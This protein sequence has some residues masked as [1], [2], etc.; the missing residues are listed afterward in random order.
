MSRFP[1]LALILLAACSAPSAVRSQPVVEPTLQPEPTLSPITLP[2]PTEAQATWWQPAFGASWQ[3][4]FTG[5]VIDTSLPVEVFDLDL[6]DTPAETVDALHASGKRVM[7]Y[8]NVG[9]WEDWRPDVAD[10]PAEVLG[11]DY[12]GWPGE[13]WLDI[14]S[15]ALRSIML[16][17]L[18]LCE[19]K[20]FDG[21]DPDNLDSFNI[22]TGFPLSEDDALDYMAWLADE[23]HAR[24]LAFGI[25]NV[26]ELASE[27]EPYADWVITE[28]CF[29]QGWCE[30]LLPFLKNGKP[31]F[32]IEYV[33]NGTSL[34]DFCAQAKELGI[35]AIL[36]M[37]ELDAWV[38]FCP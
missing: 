22:D 5:D 18:D 20:G 6:F 23:A 10:F 17:R 34:E 15:E 11:N 19:S 29:D 26:P 13:R 21:V 14:R 24:E 32:A 1:F 4:Q 35:S 9:A 7:C 3:I 16:A 25:K 33:E 12:E 31:V 8:I 30:K 38:E 28:S 27:L 37:R 36:K 2:E